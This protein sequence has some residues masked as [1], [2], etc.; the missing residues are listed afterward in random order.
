MITR[1][2]FK[3]MI[4]GGAFGDALGAPVETW[5]LEK[6]TEVYGGPLSHYVS[7]KSHKYFS[8]DTPIGSFTDDTALTM[9]VMKGL[10]NAKKLD[11]PN[12]DGYMDQISLSHVEE[13]KKSTHGWGK[14]TIEAI[15]R[16]ANGCSWKESGKTNIPHRGTGNGVVMKISPLA[17]WSVAPGNTLK[18][19]NFKYNQSFV[20]F[21]AMTH[22]SQSAAEASVL[23]ANVM[24]YLLTTESCEQFFDELFNVMIDFCFLDQKETLNEQINWKI[25]DLCSQGTFKN[26]VDD[27]IIFWKDNQKENTLISDVDKIKE[28]FGNTCYVCESLP[29]SY[30]LYLLNPFNYNSIFLAANSGGDNDTNAKIVGEMVGAVKGIQLFKSPE[31]IWSIEEMPR[32]NELMD[33]AD[34]FC[35]IFKIS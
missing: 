31:I 32:F 25:G 13:L 11:L 30:C 8:D 22:W 1:D 35:D 21:S 17:A 12:F 23:H 9:A 29:F 5:D 4:F 7:P 28:K 33:L 20:D 18:K 16:I 27:V 6:I 14:S 10:I 15:I 19:E 3:G 26:L 2:R 34:E 24:S